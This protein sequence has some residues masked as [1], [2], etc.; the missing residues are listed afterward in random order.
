MISTMMS[1]KRIRI[2]TFFETLKTK[3]NE[4]SQKGPGKL[5]LK[6]ERKKKASKTTECTLMYA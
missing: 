6:V 1:H 3:T 4:P 5:E 2:L